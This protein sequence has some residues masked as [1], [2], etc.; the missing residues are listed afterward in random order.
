MYDF[1]IL[2]LSD[3]EEI[4]SFERKKL[5]EQIADPIEQELA[6][7][8][9]PW[10]KE[11]LEFYA[12]LGWSFVA[13]DSASGQ[14]LGYFLAQPFL[15]FDGYTQTLWVEHLHCSSIQVR[16]QLCEIAYKVAREKHLQQ[17]LFP[18]R[19]LGAGG[20]VNALKPMGAKEWSTQGF[21]LK[22][23]K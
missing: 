4:E 17:V 6:S 3:L 7:W 13:R 1:Q 14:F 16:D 9:A 22:T 23:T 5:V 21:T 11:S 20:L 2:N 15:F 12:G 10:R 19:N 18:N 8:K